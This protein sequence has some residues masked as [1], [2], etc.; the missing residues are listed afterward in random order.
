[1]QEQRARY[2]PIDASPI[3]DSAV[4]VRE[5][6]GETYQAIPASD[7]LARR[8]QVR[9]PQQKRKPVG[10]RREFLDAYKPNATPYLPAKLCQKLYAIGQSE[11][12]AAMEPGTYARQVLDRL[13]ID[14]AWNS[15]RLE[16]NTY[17]LLETDHLLKLV[18]IGVSPFVFPEREIVGI[19]SK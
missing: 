3:K 16:G 19:I 7:R 12:M 14:L 13:L 11:H 5:D 4:V 15:S 2:Q 8:D 1:M 17:S 6:S 10:Y 18:Q 9:K